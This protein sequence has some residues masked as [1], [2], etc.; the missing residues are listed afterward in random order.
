MRVCASGI[1]IVVAPSL[2]LL[3]IFFFFFGSS[4]LQSVTRRRTC[5]RAFFFAIPRMI[6][7]HS[8][9]A[10]PVLPSA[11]KVQDENYVKS[12]SS[13]SSS[14]STDTTT[15]SCSSS[16]NNNNSSSSSTRTSTSTSSS[17]CTTSNDNNSGSGNSGS[18]DMKRH[19]GQAPLE[20]PRYRFVHVPACRAD[21]GDSVVYRV[22]SRRRWK[23]LT[24]EL[25][26]LCNEA[27]ERRMRHSM[28]HAK[29][30]SKPLNLNYIA[31]RL[32]LDEPTWGYCVRHR[33]SGWL[34]GFVT[35]TTF[36]SWHEWLHWD[37]LSVDAQLMPEPESTKSSS[38]SSSSSSAAT[39]RKAAAMA[40]VPASGSI[41][42]VDL[43][44]YSPAER[45]WIRLRK[46]DQDGKLSRELEAEMRLS[47]P[48]GRNAQVWPH[49][50]EVSLLGGLGAG[51]LL[52]EKLL[53]Q[54]EAPDSQYR[55]V[56]THATHG[57]IPF[58]EKLGFVRVGAIVRHRR[59][60]RPERDPHADALRAQA[61][62]ACVDTYTVPATTSL[63]D[64]AASLHQQIYLDAV[65]ISDAERATA[66]TLQ[67]VVFDLTYLNASLAK[68][69]ADSSSVV[70][71]KGTVLRVPAKRFPGSMRSGTF[72]W[73]LW[74]HHTAH[75]D[76]TPGMVYVHQSLTLFAFA[77]RS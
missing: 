22:S 5:E 70:V 8:Q 14:T 29:N 52:M 74:D 50:A 46:V 4:V 3:F 56:V 67:D 72:A 10:L 27:L 1:L 12:S 42:T 24:P 61:S 43:S 9:A 15:T 33:D 58:Y 47:D 75:N 37:S 23:Q 45:D 62:R 11:L 17:S 65:A 32:D 55:F 68:G 48:S 49:V 77:C 64:L 6:S 26:L 25:L 16:T 36:S 44:A 31:D 76:D 21:L 73:D 30:G 66:P 2:S 41:S 60:K 63:L 53:E 51:R 69:D 18:E 28:E 38:S 20:Q 59:R 39:K 57:S 7:M 71:E 13:S 19:G 54:L 34:Q 35:A 40:S